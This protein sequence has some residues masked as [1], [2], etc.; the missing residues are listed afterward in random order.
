ML[1]Y[2]TRCV[3]PSTKPD[4]HLNE[5]GVCNACVAYEQ[6][7]EVD[8]DA[9]RSELLQLLK[10]YRRDGETWD[11]IVPVSG[12]KDIRI[13]VR[14]VAAIEPLCVTA[15]TCDLSDIGRR[16]IDNI[17]ARCRLRR[18]ASTPLRAWLN[19]LVSRRLAH[20]RPGAVGIST[21]PNPCRRAVQRASG[22]ARIPERVWRSGPPPETTLTRRWLEEFE[23]CW[24]WVS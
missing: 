10:R 24:A 17:N 19:R 12:G 13:R 18:E 20:S 14:A 15:T 1:T 2:C 3:M 21:D 5:Q 6:R 4:L 22:R 9:R 16:N 7:K 11:G 23:G 8:W